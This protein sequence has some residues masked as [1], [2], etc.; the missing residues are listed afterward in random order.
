MNKKAYY[1]LSI[2]ILVI[3]IMIRANSLNS[4][5]KTI[6]FS[7]ILLNDHFEQITSI[8]VLKTSGY[9]TA[10][11]KATKTESDI[12]ITRLNRYG[13]II[14]EKTYGS[15]AWDKANSILP[16]SDKGYV[17]IGETI[18]KHAMGRM[19]QVLKLDKNGKLVWRKYFNYG[20]DNEVNDVII[21]TNGNYIIVGSIFFQKKKK[22]YLWILELNTKGHVIMNKTLGGN[23][24]NAG[25]SI[26]KTYDKG[27]IIAGV[28]ETKKTGLKDIWIVKF[29]KTF[30]KLWEK[31]Y[32]N[33]Y[34]DS[35][36]SIIETSRTNYIVAGYTYRSDSGKSSAWILKLDRRGKKLWDRVYGGKNWDDAASVIET[37]N[38]EY[39]FTGYTRSKGLNN[40]DGW[41][42]K[43]DNNGK[44]LWDRTYGDLNDDEILSIA[45]TDDGF[46]AAG[47]SISPEAEV[48]DAW[49]LKTDNDGNYRPAKPEIFSKFDI[50]SYKKPKEDMKFYLLWDKIYGSEKEEAILS[51]CSTEN[52]DFIAAGF[53]ESKGK[54]MRDA[55]I[56][57]I[58]KNGSLQWGRTYGG[59][60]DDQINSI[61]IAPD[62]MII[63]TG[64]T[65]SKGQG[66]ADVWVLKLNYKGFKLWEKTFGGK[67]DD[68]GISILSTRDNGFIIAGT[69]LSHGKGGS[70]IW[71]IKLNRKGVKEWDKTFGGDA[72]D[73]AFS[74]SQ[75]KE[76]GYIIAG[77]TYSKGN[78]ESDIWII[79]LNSKGQLIWEKTFGGPYHDGVHAIRETERGGYIMAGYSYTKSGESD[80]RIIR[81]SANGAILWDKQY[82]RSL[83][84]TAYSVEQTFDKGF[85]VAGTIFSKGAGNWDIWIMK[86]SERGEMIWNKTYGGDAKESVSTI[87]QINKSEYM[88]SGSTSSKG[89]GAQDFLLIK[90]KEIP[91]LNK[92]MIKTV[93]DKANIYIN[94]KLKGLSPLNISSEKKALHHLKIQK[95]DYYEI[96]DNIPIDNV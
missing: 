73:E 96:E 81:L 77:H 51:I 40:K 76:D 7:K 21:K 2:L 35:A 82:D 25:Y 14:W 8:R 37:G 60:S 38:E 42:V 3:L 43:I 49:I 33:L 27:Y 89:T 29:N 46:I 53:T 6:C 83:V 28:T 67:Q 71:I 61:Q 34:W 88:I 59:N 36:N 54:N 50:S 24:W 84:D 17:V 70:D 15:K 95:A 72:D 80:I 79:K 48:Q 22:S 78:G 85:V 74:I 58:N 11:Y 91:G 30:K 18:S 5:E 31:K 45:S 20:D 94:N 10:G 41:M 62:G 87:K 55:L 75:T 1:I 93:P 39:V 90:F 47:Y 23:N 26:K 52:D 16:T 86:L 12:W 92:I 64:Y 69:T 57:G 32:G 44:I 56:A 19:A 13:K 65:R 4:R 9:I 63:A 68:K 66:K